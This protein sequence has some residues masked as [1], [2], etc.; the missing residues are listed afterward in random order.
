MG[1]N[2][3]RLLRKH[4]HECHM[5]D[6]G[7]TAINQ[8]Y[9]QQ[10]ENLSLE[11]FVQHLPKPRIVWVMVPT[12]DEFATLADRLT[13]LLEPGDIVIDNKNS[14]CQGSEYCAETLKQRG[15]HY[16]DVGTST[17]ALS[18]KRGYCFMI[19]GDPEVVQ[20]LE[21]VFQA[22]AP[23]PKNKAVS[24]KSNVSNLKR[25]RYKSKST[26]SHLYC[27]E[28]GAGHFAR[29]FYEGAEQS[30]M[31][32]Y[33]EVLAERDRPTPDPLIPVPSRPSTTTP[34]AK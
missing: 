33:A 3:K 21:P 10:A 14:Y 2:L 34:S 32:A 27:G 18:V 19:G 7:S 1:N 13:T 31:R 29:Q 24:T 6:C 23:V 20:Y 28:A 9:N 22:L 15:I 16:V 17:A 8:G 30:L 12:S 25:K 5:F 26:V 4:G 11:A